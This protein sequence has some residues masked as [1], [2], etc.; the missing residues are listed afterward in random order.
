VLSL[1]KVYVAHVPDGIQQ[2]AGAKWSDARMNVKQ[3]AMRK[4]VT[5]ILGSMTAWNIGR[6][7]EEEDSEEPR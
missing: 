3:Q 4:N 6:V 5:R 7:L 1:I 2:I